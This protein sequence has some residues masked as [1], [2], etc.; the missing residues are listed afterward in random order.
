LPDEELPDEE[1]PDEEL[2]DEELPDEEL[3]DE[4]P[5]NVKQRAQKA[6]DAK[7][8]RN[9]IARIDNRIK[10]QLNPT[11]PTKPDEEP[12]D[13]EEKPKRKSL[14]SL[15]KRRKPSP[16]KKKGIEKEPLGD[17]PKLEPE[18]EP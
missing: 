16:F 9:L 4:E 3:P 17:E 6:V 10:D 7:R 15:T 14:I 13:I 18:P 2:P 8:S 11:K 5:E 12:E 1:L